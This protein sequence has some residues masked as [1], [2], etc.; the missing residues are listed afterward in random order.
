MDGRRKSLKRKH[1]EAE[2]EADEAMEKRQK[3]EEKHEKFRKEKEELLEKARREADEK[4]AELMEQAK[5]DVDS[6]RSQWEDQFE[7]ERSAFISNL[8]RSAA[9]EIMKITRR[10]LEDLA[11]EGLEHQM[12]RK[13]SE[14]I[15]HAGEEDPSATFKAARVVSSFSLDDELREELS[16]FGESLEFEETDEFHGIALES[17]GTRITWSVESWL[18]DFEHE[19]QER[20]EK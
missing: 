11:G 12:V 13:L 20:L 10:A 3:L 7:K 1:E 16:R 5:Q 9:S 2:A 8:K 15:Q 17:D 18:D 19:M 4:R 6:K 14:S